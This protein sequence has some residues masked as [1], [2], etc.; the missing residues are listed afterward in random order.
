MSEE[1]R[2]LRS[3][4]MEVILRKCDGAIQEPSWPA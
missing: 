2:E 3:P 4:L 1:L